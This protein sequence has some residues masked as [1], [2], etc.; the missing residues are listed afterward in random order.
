MSETA[1]APPRKPRGARRWLYVVLL[2]LFAYVGGYL[3]LRSAGRLQLFQGYLGGS[4]VAD[5]NSPITEV[6]S[7]GVEG[8]RVWP[9]TWY[10]PCIAVEEW[11]RNR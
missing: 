1:P 10:F 6:E 5:M 3:G 11:W 4:Y 8:Q 7:G 2:L 9:A